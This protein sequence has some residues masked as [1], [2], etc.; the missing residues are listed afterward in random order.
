MR[1]VLMPAAR[2][3]STAAI[4]GASG[5]RPAK[6]RSIR[7]PAGRR[8]AARRSRAR[9]PRRRPRRAPARAAAPVPRRRRGRG[10][11]RSPSRGPRPRRSVEALPDVRRE[12]PAE[13]D[14]QPA[15]PAFGHATF[16]PVARRIGSRGPWARRRRATAQKGS[17]PRAS[18]PGSRRT[19][20][21]RPGRFEYDRIAGGRSNLTYSVRTRRATAGRCVGRRWARRSAPP[22]TWAASTASSPHWHPP[23]FPSLRSRAIAPTRRSTARPST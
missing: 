10:R 7:P 5:S 4:I 14:E 8:R 19:S 9:R 23:T 21:A 16:I 2:A 11:G 13:V 22:T 20:T 6:S 15:D 17:M 3:R 18:A 1:P 12:H